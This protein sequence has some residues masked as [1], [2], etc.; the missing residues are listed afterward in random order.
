MPAHRLPTF[1]LPEKSSKDFV[2]LPCDPNGIFSS[3]YS[4]NSVAVLN[5]I[6]PEK[7][8]PEE[9]TTNANIGSATEPLAGLADLVKL[10][11]QGIRPKQHSTLTLV[12]FRR[13][14]HLRLW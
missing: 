2:Y 3:H 5:C 12:E 13:R 8:C 9:A 4:A 14:V 7:A 11:Y 6:D 10:A 1:A